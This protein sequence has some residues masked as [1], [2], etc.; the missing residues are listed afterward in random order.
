MEWLQVLPLDGHR[1][2]QKSMPTGG[3]PMTKRKPPCMFMVLSKI[4]GNASENPSG[5]PRFSEINGYCEPTHDHHL[6]WCYIILY[7]LSM[8]RM[9]VFNLSS[10]FVPFQCHLKPSKSGKLGGWNSHSAKAKQIWPGV[11]GVTLGPGV[12]GAW[13]SS[14]SSVSWPWLYE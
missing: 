12:A 10:L 2:S 3:T 1:T 9:S 14:V 4:M 11:T 13:D 7:P 8:D 6:S 5:D